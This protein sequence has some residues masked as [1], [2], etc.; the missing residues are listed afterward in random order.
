MTQLRFAQQLF[1]L[2]CEFTVVAA[3]VRA[4]V[5]A[6]LLLT[7]NALGASWMPVPSSSQ[8][9]VDWIFGEAVFWHLLIECLFHVAASR[10]QRR[11][12]RSFFC[13][14]L[15]IFAHHHSQ[16]AGSFLNVIAMRRNPCKSWTEAACAAD[17]SPQ[18]I[19]VWRST[20]HANLYDFW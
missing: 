13:G 11:P 9:H 8:S 3:S 10:W 6:S 18:I 14:H 20:R 15:A 1:L 4:D 7:E 2:A 12:D 19:Y 5:L 16:T 17:H